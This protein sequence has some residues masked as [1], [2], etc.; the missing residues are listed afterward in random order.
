[1]NGNGSSAILVI[2]ATT[3]LYILSKTSVIKELEV[4]KIEVHLS[5]VIA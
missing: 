5:T 3:N 1:M 4:A 2:K